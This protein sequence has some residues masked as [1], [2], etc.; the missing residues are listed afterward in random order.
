VEPWAAKRIIWNT[1]TWFYKRRNIEFDPTGLLSVDAGVFNPLLG[2]SYS[3]IA[4]RSRSA[5]KTQGFG[6]T[7]E[8][9]PS[10][11]YFVHLAGTPTTNNLLDDIDTSWNRV[12]GSEAVVSAITKSIEAFSANDPARSVPHL[13]EA[14]RA[15]RALP[16]DYWKTRKLARY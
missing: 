3:E 6:A 5:H 13:I 8:L 9:G 12:P 7:A 15:L 10:M 2:A 1:S 4:A 11:E 16:D 14:H